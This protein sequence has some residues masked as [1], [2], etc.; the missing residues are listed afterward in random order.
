[1][2][3]QEQN[4]SEIK[5][6]AYGEGVGV[7]DGVEQTLEQTPS[8]EADNTSTVVM[9]LVA[10]FG[11]VAFWSG[12][13]IM[14]GSQDFDPMVY[15]PARTV[16][17]MPVEPPTL[18]EIGEKVFN[19][20][21]VTCH[22]ADGNGVPGTFPTL[23]G[24]QWVNGSKERVI[25]ILLSGLEGPIEINGTV[26]DGAMPQWG[27]AL[28]DKEIAGVLSYVRT[29]AEWGNASSEVTEQEVAA[30][31]TAYGVRPQAWTVETLV[32]E[33]PDEAK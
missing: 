16:A 12:A 17:A 28:K 26:Y 31:R 21:C 24:T 9:V 18:I 32:A 1:M 14:Q 7:A 4:N 30:M 8:V 13:R 29:K 15:N 22:M 10:I 20:H 19:K 23:H 6:H 11:L 2:P 33:F 5:T 3:D 25:N 27:A